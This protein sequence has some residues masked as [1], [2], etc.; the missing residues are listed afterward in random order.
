MC[1]IDLFKVKTTDFWATYIH[2]KIRN[3]N[4]NGTEW[5]E[6]IFVLPTRNG[7]V[8]SGSTHGLATVSLTT[9][10]QGRDFFV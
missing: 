7:N 2:S 10:R 9:T 4:Y 1:D 8:L 6:N 5:F 3:Y